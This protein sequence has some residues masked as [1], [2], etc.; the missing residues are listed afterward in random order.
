VAIHCVENKIPLFVEKPITRNLLGLNEIQNHS[1]AA[2]NFIQ[3]GYN[4]RFSESIN[5]VKNSI[6]EKNINKIEINYHTN[7]PQQPLWNLNSLVES[8][9]LAIAVHPLNTA[10]H[11][12]GKIK[13]INQLVTT[14]ENNRINIKVELLHQNQMFSE[15]NISNTTDKF[16]MNI[17]GLAD[18]ELK[19]FMPNLL[20]VC[21]LSAEQTAHTIYKQSSLKP[22]NLA[23]GYL[24][25][26]THFFE[27]LRNNKATSKSDI[28]DSIWMYELF[29]KILKDES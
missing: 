5:V 26:F 11:L 25:Q 17:K 1:K 20:E 7:K 12:L 4:L 27:D 6:S 22:I 14:I 23:S 9:L 10:Y 13:K 16:D 3:V 18:T 8:F 29:E 15:V 19:L 28:S 21:E 2:G 24:Q